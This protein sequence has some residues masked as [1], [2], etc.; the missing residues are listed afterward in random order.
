MWIHRGKSHMKTQ[1]KWI[2]Y[3]PSR[4]AW[5]ETNS[6]TPSSQASKPQDCVTINVCC[7]NH[8]VGGSLI[9]KP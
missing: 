4:E 8:P 7:L 2:I 1:G 3:K 5:E 6:L 9:W